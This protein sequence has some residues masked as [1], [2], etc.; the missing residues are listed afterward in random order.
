MPEVLRTLLNITESLTQRKLLE[1]ASV[2]SERMLGLASTLDRLA[3][4]PTLLTLSAQ[5]VAA[6]VFS[7]MGTEAAGAF[8]EGHR[9]AIEVYIGLE[10]VANEGGMRRMGLVSKAQRAMCLW[11]LDET[12]SAESLFREVASAATPNFLK[13]RADALLNLSLVLAETGRSAEG[14][15]IALEG[16]RLYLEIGDHASARDAERVLSVVRG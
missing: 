6:N 8:P 10:K 1:E 7:A 3:G 9:R 4:G 13:T 14:E 11:H 15:T 2:R 5:G 16:L 12:D